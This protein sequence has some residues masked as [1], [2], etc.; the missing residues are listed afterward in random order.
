MYFF[1][2]LYRYKNAAEANLGQIQVAMKKRLDMIEQ[3]LGAVKGYVNYERDVF[4][5]VSRMRSRVMEAQAG[6]LEEINRESRSIF[7]AVLAVAEDYPELKAN[8]TVTKLM[9]AIIS[10]EDEIARHRYTFNNIVQE[11]NTM[12][13]TIPSNIVARSSCMSKMEYLEFE[14]EVKEAP[15]IEGISEE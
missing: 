4:E 2:R 8:E 14:E 1:N 9:D 15:I 10:V 7:S 3:L 12:V 11:F 6:G 5:T 13:D